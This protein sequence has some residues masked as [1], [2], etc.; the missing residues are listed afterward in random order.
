ML[1]IPASMVSYANDLVH[2]AVMI[3]SEEYGFDSTEALRLV[4]VIGI[5]EKVNKVNKVKK[6]E[7]EDKGRLNYLKWMNIIKLI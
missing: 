1:N 4:G 6:E 2:K 7:K 3:C 5:E